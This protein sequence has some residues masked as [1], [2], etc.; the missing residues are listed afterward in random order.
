[1]KE[2]KLRYCDKYTEK[3][4]SS[5]YETVE[6]LIP[7]NANKSCVVNILQH[8]KAHDVLFKA[9]AYNYFKRQLVKFSYNKTC[10]GVVNVLRVDDG[11]YREMTVNLIGDDKSQKKVRP[12]LDD[13]FG[14]FNVNQIAFINH[15]DLRI[16]FRRF[17]IH[18]RSYLN[19][20]IQAA[21]DYC[22]E[23]EFHLNL[24]I[25]YFGIKSLSD[26]E[27]GEIYNQTQI[28]CFKNFSVSNNFVEKSA[29]QFN[30]DF[31]METPFKSSR[32]CDEVMQEQVESVITIDLFGFTE[33]SQRV[34][35]CIM[36][37]NRDGKFIEQ[38]VIMPAIVRYIDVDYEIPEEDFINNSKVVIGI[39]FEC[40][41]SY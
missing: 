17:G 20:I 3:F 13:L 32:K 40:L 1:M 18:L 5:F 36:D 4:K 27:L 11:K 30:D 29:Y 24:N 14:G 37:R 8:H 41:Q 2:N 23:S 35:D 31:S 34:M 15:Q 9:I 21:K 22:T 25:K 19:G 38:I 12:C 6:P 7:T 28:E 16:G 33:P 39:M 10:S 26:D